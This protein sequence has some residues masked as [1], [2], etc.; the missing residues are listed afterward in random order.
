MSMTFLAAK[1]DVARNL[2]G[3]AVSAQLTI[4]G[5]SIVDAIR[6]F[7]TFDPQHQWEYKLVTLSTIPVLA[8]TATYTLT[9]PTTSIKKIHSARLTTNKRV[10]AYARQRH[11]DRVIRDQES[12]DVTVAYIEVLT[13]TGVGITLVPT[14]SSADTLQVRVYET[15]KTT[16]GDSDNLDVLDRHIPAV[17]A[18]ARYS[19][20]IDRNADDP[21]ADKYYGI[22]EQM[23]AKCVRDDA[24]NPDEDV[25]LTPMDEWAGA[26]DADPLG[27]IVDDGWGW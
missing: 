26:Y 25:R 19:M 12:N 18:R 4:A 7:D 2:G 16:Y 13:A 10:L 5:Q 24:G 6:Y 14:P 23:I 11:V 27:G 21:R 15:I 3:S 1:Q 17:L 8:G 22:A 9:A 20:L